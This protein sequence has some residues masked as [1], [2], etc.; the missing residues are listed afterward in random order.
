M[1]GKKSMRKAAAKKSNRK[2]K[3]S[4]GRYVS[5]LLKN[6]SKTKMTM[7]RGGMKVMN[8][9]A[10][11]V[12]D[13]LAGQAAELARSAKRRT[14]GS[15]EFQCA[16]RLTFPNDLSRHTMAEATKAVAKASA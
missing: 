12:L 11:D 7:S 1:A 9:I 2:P 8:S 15:R 3:R 10:A 5:A 14:L 6:A 4:F 16:V 13:R